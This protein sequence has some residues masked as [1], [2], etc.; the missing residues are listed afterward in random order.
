[1]IGMAFLRLKK[2][3]KSDEKCDRISL[4]FSLDSQERETG[5]WCRMAVHRMQRGCCFL[6]AAGRTDVLSLVR[7]PKIRI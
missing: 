6:M 1:M 2:V 7:T 4:D 5:T 3:V